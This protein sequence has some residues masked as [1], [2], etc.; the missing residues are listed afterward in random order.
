MKPQ[1]KVLDLQ[2]LLTLKD[3][4]KNEIASRQVAQRELDNAIN[5]VVPLPLIDPVTLSRAKQ[6]RQAK[7]RAREAFQSIPKPRREL[8]EHVHKTALEIALGVARKMGVNYSGDTSHEAWFGPGATAYTTTYQGEQYSRSCKYSKTNATHCIQLTNA[9]H[10]IQLDP[11]RAHALVESD[12]LRELSHRDGLPLIALDDDGKAAWVVTKGKRI[13]AEHG[14]IIGDDVCCYHST[15]SREHAVGG[16]ARKRAEIDRRNAEAAERERLRKAS[17]EYKAERRARLM[18]RLCGSLT[19]TIADAK[20]C[21]YCDPGIAEFQRRH[22]IGDTA[23][24]PELVRTGNSLA[25][26]L[27]LKLARQAAKQAA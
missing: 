2:K 10:C 7:E 16:H 25:V 1:T 22:G 21:G 8:A 4:G 23:T 27:A 17:P 3:A 20:S 14:W 12:R 13:S 24:L 18:A 26:S 6:A 11:A 9:T 15:K 5:G 19:A